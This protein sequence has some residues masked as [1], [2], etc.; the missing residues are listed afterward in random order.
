MG[1]RAQGLVPEAHGRM[2]RVGDFRA[3]RA[4]VRACRS[5]KWTP[6]LRQACGKYGTVVSVDH[7][8]NTAQVRIHDI[9]VLAW[10]PLSVL[11]EEPEEDDDQDGRMVKVSS[12]EELRAAVDAHPAITWNDSF[13][14]ACG[15]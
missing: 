12:L 7:S 14:N 1:A 5:L 8:D 15:Q 9:G 3:V 13:A 4:A 2:V 11:K 6:A 10:F